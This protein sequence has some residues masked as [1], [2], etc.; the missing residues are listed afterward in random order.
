VGVPQRVGDGKLGEDAGGEAEVDADR[1]DVA[2]ADA[3]AG[4]DDQ[5]MVG[6]GRPDRLDQRVGARLSAV[7][8]RAAADLDDVA[9]REHPHHGGLGRGHHLLV[10]QALPHQQRPDVVTAIRHWFP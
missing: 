1:E 10:E 4:A 9:I 8:D 6:E 3:T 2:A 7:E 5:F